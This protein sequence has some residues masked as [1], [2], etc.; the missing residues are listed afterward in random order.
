MKYDFFS[1]MRFEQVYTEYK[2]K[3][4]TYTVIIGALLILLIM[5]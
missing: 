1:D 2:R 4:W 5:L 3:G